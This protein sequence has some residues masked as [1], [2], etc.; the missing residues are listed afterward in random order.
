MGI[1][2]VVKKPNRVVCGLIL[3][4]NNHA[5]YNKHSYCY[6]SGF[7]HNNMAVNIAI[8]SGFAGITSTK[9]KAMQRDEEENE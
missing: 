6:R 4:N 7:A 9:N 3:R 5:E 8:S 2:S 1:I